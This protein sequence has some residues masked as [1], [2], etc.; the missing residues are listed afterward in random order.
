MRLKSRSR[1]GVMCDGN[2]PTKHSRRLGSATTVVEV[3]NSRVCVCMII[4]IRVYRSTTVLLSS[5]GRTNLET[6]PP[7][8]NTRP[9]FRRLMHLD[10]R[11]QIL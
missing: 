6:N 10:K 9:V 5:V 3:L 11:V 7:I 1:L 4:D 2:A 8:R